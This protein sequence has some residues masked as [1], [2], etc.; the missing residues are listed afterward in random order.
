MEFRI[1]LNV[2]GDAMESA[3]ALELARILRRLA[4]NLESGARAIGEDSF[5]TDYNGNTVGKVSWRGGRAECGACGG[6]GRV[7][8]VDMLGRTRARFAVCPICKGRD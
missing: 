6:G 4:D 7:S 1:R 2:A 8:G 5:L 3:P